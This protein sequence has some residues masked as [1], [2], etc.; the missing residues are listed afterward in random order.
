MQNITPFPEI[1]VPAAAGTAA[2]IV[3]Y[4]PDEDFDRRLALL[5]GQFAAVF[6]VD[7]TAGSM[8]ERQTRSDGGVYYLPQGENTGLDCALN[9][10]CDAAV[11]AGFD[12]VVTFDQDSEVAAD[13][14]AQQI[15]FW[16]LSQARVFLLGCNYSDGGD[17]GRSRSR[18]SQGSYVVECA[19][20][21]TS[22]CLMCL[23][24][25][26]KLGKFCEGYFIDGV[27][28]E[29][30]LRARS[31]HLVVARH[32][33][34]LMQHRIGERSAANRLL[35]YLH[36]PV[37]KYYGMRNGVRNSIQYASNEPLWSLRKCISLAWEVVVVLF[38]ESGKQ[39]K[40]KAMLRGVADGVTGRMGVAPD[41]L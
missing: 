5:S 35:P 14:L 8:V 21:I 18:F 1:P 25:W 10:G 16:H 30:C 12:W 23:S 34:V 4:H 29:I 38:L 15:A 22:G 6:W 3:S 41:D 40:L 17:G 9:R 19:T 7:N 2:V 24:H 32:G 36:S 27:D 11:S 37:R 13:F 33:R 31:R 26:S 28:H 20:V 39:A